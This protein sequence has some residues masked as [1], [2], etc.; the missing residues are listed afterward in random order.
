MHARRFGGANLIFAK[1]ASSLG[2]PPS[3]FGG[4]VAATDRVQT[5]HLA[6]GARTSATVRVWWLAAR[7][8]LLGPGAAELSRD[9]CILPQR[10]GIAWSW[11]FQEG[12]QGQ[13]RPYLRQKKRGQRSGSAWWLTREWQMHT[14]V[15]RPDH[16]LGPQRLWEGCGSRNLQHVRTKRPQAWIWWRVFTSSRIRR[17]QVGSDAN[18]ARLRRPA[19]LSSRTGCERSTTSSRVREPR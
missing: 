4:G 2:P 13:S 19:N 9:P 16:D 7:P 6:I 8:T 15:G 5:M 11:R 12:R 18:G 10:V 14:I 17:W 1:T 3:T